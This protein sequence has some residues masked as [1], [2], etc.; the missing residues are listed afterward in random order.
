MELNDIQ[1]SFERAAKRQKLS[2]SKSEELID[3]LKR[4]IEQALASIAPD[5]DPPI[6]VDLKETLVD[7]RTKLQAFVAS[8]DS[9]GE[10]QKEPSTTLAKHQKLLEQTFHPDISQALLVKVDFAPDAMNQVITAHLYRAGLFDVADSMAMEAP[11]GPEP[12]PLRPDFQKLHQ[13]LDA[14]RRRDVGPALG[15]ASANRE[16]LGNSSSTIELK[17]HELRFFHILQNLTRTDALEYARAH[18]APFATRHMKD[19]QKV[20]GSLLWAGRL[21]KSP[22]ADLASPA[23]WDRL[24][25]ELTRMFLSFLGQPLGDPLDVAVRAGV[26]GLPTILKLASVMDVK[27]Q[28]WLGLK[29]LP[30][31]VELGGEFQFHSVFVCP[32]SREEGSEENPPMMLTCGHVL[33]KQSILKMS[34]TN[35]QSF[36]C[37]YCPRYMSSVHCKRLHF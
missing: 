27:K 28:E 10:V 16:S 34:K 6:P 19:V 3:Q 36:K 23:S 5:N 22:Y 32:V 37:P 17:F 1:D 13:M 24:A 31:P 25:G 2:S 11:G 4:E 18:V 20:M 33:C 8:L 12:V 14:L 15:W 35:T 26:E 7:L 30:V 9:L 29:Q 21:D